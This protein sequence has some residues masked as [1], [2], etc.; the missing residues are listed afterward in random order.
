[1]KQTELLRVGM[2]AI[3][4]AAIGVGAGAPSARAGVITLDVSGTLIPTSGGAACSPTCTIGG[5]IVINN[6][7]GAPNGGFV[8]ADVTAAGF[9]PSVGPFTQDNGIFAP[10]G[11]LT[12]LSIEDAGGTF[13]GLLF[14]TPTAGSLVGYSGGTLSTL[15][16]ASNLQ[17]P[18]V[19][20][21]TSGSLTQ[22]AAVPEPSSLLLLFTAL[23]GLCGLFGKRLL[24]QRPAYR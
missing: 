11:G 3:A 12:E 14:S 18:P 15:T 6:S 22:A 20:R 8:S 10:G 2:L 7:P 5:D 1:M 24:W 23:A 21:L 19:W 16:T 9:S 17:T 4:C 13:L